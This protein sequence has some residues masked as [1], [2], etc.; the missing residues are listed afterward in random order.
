MWQQLSPLE[1]EVAQHAMRVQLHQHSVD[2]SVLSRGMKLYRLNLSHYKKLCLL[3]L[4]SCGGS[5]GGNLH[6][7][8]GAGIVRISKL[9]S[10]KLVYCVLSRYHLVLGH[11]FQMTLGKQ[12]FNVLRAWFDVRLEC[13]ASPLN[14]T[15]GAY[16]L[17]FLLTDQC[18]GA[19]GNFFSLRLS[20]SS[21]EANPLVLPRLCWQWWCTYTSCCMTPPGQ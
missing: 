18:F 9:D 15:C 19:V 20:S 12:A 21:F 11:G 7:C 5:V 14:C 6:Q 13:F 4:V 3:A 16:M 17:A 1:E 2:F 10:N 8:A